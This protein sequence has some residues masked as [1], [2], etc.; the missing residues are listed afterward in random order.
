MMQLSGEAKA[1]GAQMS[2]VIEAL[3]QKYSAEE[4]HII[5]LLPN[6]TDTNKGNPKLGKEASVAI[7]K[8][9]IPGI[10]PGTKGRTIR[11]W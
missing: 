1:S 5:L 3:A 8:V 10:D 6:G 9:L 2:A 11:Q 4:V 7:V